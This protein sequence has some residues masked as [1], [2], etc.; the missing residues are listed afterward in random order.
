MGYAQWW[1][2]S[3]ISW[4]VFGKSTAQRYTGFLD[5]KFLFGLFG[6]VTLRTTSRVKE[7]E[8]S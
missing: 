2:N 1:L 5:I 6:D 8:N 7:K 4:M 3:K